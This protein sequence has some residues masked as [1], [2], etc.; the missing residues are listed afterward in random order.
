MLPGPASPSA[1]T[2]STAVERSLPLVLAYVLGPLLAMA[3]RFLGPDPSWVFLAERGIWLG[4]AG[5]G[6]TRA[7]MGRNTPGGLRAGLPLTAGFVLILAALAL[8]LSWSPPDAIRLWLAE[9]SP[10]AWLG[11]A[12]LWGWTVAPPR[13]RDFLSAGTGLA[14]AVLADLI[15]TSLLAWRPMLS[16]GFFFPSGLDRVETHATLLLAAFAAGQMTGLDGA[17]E[18][19]RVRIMRFLVLAGLLATFSRTALCAA[20]CLA[21]L[22]GRG[23]WRRRSVT[24][25]LCLACAAVPVV[26]PEL[27]GLVMER[28]EA[29]LA[30][31]GVIRSVLDQPFLLLTGVS[32]TGTMALFLPPELVRELSLPSDVIRALPSSLGSSWLR[33][34]A[35][36]GIWGWLALAAGASGL[37]VR[38]WMRGRNSP[39]L[40]KSVAVVVI[41]LFQGLLF[42][43]TYLPAAMVPLFLLLFLS[44]G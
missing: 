20:F 10:L 39:L 44:D 1:K 19:W 35:V 16:G 34:L 15:V 33:F 4:L 11:L 24:A 31:V 5:F 17:R 3:T 27:P 29:R 43:L 32:P 41:C 28:F 12:L 22:M 2:E 18:P 9:F 25:A 30:W 8:A 26:L 14:L 36:W 6:L 40:H 42:P 23:S 38:G 13:P 7:L 37:L 21:L